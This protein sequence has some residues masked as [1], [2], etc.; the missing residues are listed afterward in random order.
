MKVRSAA[1]WQARWNVAAPGLLLLLGACLG[2]ASL[3]LA[4]QHPVAPLAL[5][6]TTLLVILWNAARP[7][8][9][10]FLLPAA[11]PMMSFTPWTGWWLLDESDVLVLACLAGAF[12]R[13][14]VDVQ[15]GRT[16]ECMPWRRSFAAL[17]CAVALSLLLG[18]LRGVG[19]AG[20]DWTTI[21]A[22][23]EAMYAGY[24]ST[25][26][27]WRVAKS[28]AWALLIGMLLHAPGGA[29]GR[30]PARLVARGMVVGLGLVGAIAL[31]ERAVYAGIFD[32]SHAYRTSAWFWEMHVGGGAIDAYMAIA[33]PFA[34]WAMWTSTSTW[35]WAGANILM[36]LS[37]YAVLTTY[38]RGVY[39]AV[40]IA[41]LFMGITAWRFK[42]VPAGGSARG[43]RTLLA[44]VSTLVL[45]SVLVLGGGSFMAERLAGSGS[46]L[47]GRME[48]WRSSLSLL[49]SPEAWTTGLGIGRFPAHYSREVTGG[50]YPGEALWHGDA[51][52][53]THVLLSGRHESGQHADLFALTQRVDL[54]GAGSIRV[55][56]RATGERPSTLLVSL[57]ERHLLYDF[58]CQRRWASLKPMSDAGSGWI[59][60]RMGK[61]L[62]DGKS[63]VASLRES[64]FALSPMHIEQAIRIER[65][66]LWDSSG[67]Q[68]LLNT[69]FSKGLQHWLPMAQGRF[70]PW[71]IDNLYLDVLVERGLLGLVILALWVL[72]AL[73]GLWEKLRQGDSVAWAL[74]ASMVGIVSLGAVISVTE[75]PR[76]S[77]ILM[78]L[79][80]SSDG[81]RGQIEDVSRCNKS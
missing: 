71:H 3:G 79:L 38:S 41:L 43:R 28:L 25:W 22:W 42:L 30:G 32:F 18:V 9:L 36:V 49:K 40:L 4:V 19:D 64:V 70:Q 80:W 39:L 16:E 24:D 58:S 13:W 15:R 47:V 60:L 61:N 31:W 35:R 33:V 17:W 5:P 2:L 21:P 8:V 55:R 65:V 6:L 78:I 34:V 48:H 7:Q 51:G 67:R 68:R 29:G 44:M 10:W 81:F 53:Q 20:V 72:W 66:E 14:G 73:R 23:N 69:D 37:V 74:A 27:T 59:E 76:V 56:L 11:L 57:C 45:E 12:A 75:V 54:T 46:D 63:G 62:F 50:H 26:N 52:E 1:L 77:L